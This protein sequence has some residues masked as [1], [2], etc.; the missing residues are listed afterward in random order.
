MVLR[1]CAERFLEALL[2]I[3]LRLIGATIIWVNDW[4]EWKDI[5]SSVSGDLE[6]K[7]VL[8]ATIL[9]QLPSHSFPLRMR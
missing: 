5:L 3:F 1:S 8:L 7:R 6:S 4:T 2:Y 9:V